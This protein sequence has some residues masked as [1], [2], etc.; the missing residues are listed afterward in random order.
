V[1]RIE[2]AA[3]KLQQ[4]TLEAHFPVAAVGSASPDP[5]GCARANLTVYGDCLGRLDAEALE[6]LL[7]RFGSVHPQASAQR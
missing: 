3:E 2:L 1:Q 7:E 6:V 4:R 5:A